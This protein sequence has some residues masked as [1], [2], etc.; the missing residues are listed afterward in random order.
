MDQKHEREYSASRKTQPGLL[1]N[2]KSL[3]TSPNRDH[4]D[5]VDD[6]HLPLEKIRAGLE[7]AEAFIKIALLVQS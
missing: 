4:G 6:S 5:E 7:W 2:T 1:G 3:W